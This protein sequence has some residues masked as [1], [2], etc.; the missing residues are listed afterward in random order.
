[1]SRRPWWLGSGLLLIA[2]SALA[3]PPQPKPASTAQPQPPRPAAPAAGASPAPA[4]RLSAAQ[5]RQAVTALLRDPSGTQLGSAVIVA[6][7]RGGHWLVS[8]RHVVQDQR[9]VCVQPTN[10]PAA[11]A[12]VL[13]EPQPRREGG[14]DLALLWLPLSGQPLPVA[15]LASRS[16]EASAL[17]LVVASG[18]PTPLKARLEAVPYREAAGLLLPLLS[19]PLEGG[20]DLAYSAEVEK[21]MSGGGLFAGL[22]L[23]GINGA[24]AQP[25]WPGQWNDASGKPVSAALNAKL[26]L[27]SLGLSVAAI[28]TA[29]RNALPPSPATLAPLRSLRCSASPASVPPRPGASS[30]R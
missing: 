5:H 10:R 28:Q 26:E 2:A 13:P 12:V 3:A 27:V 14:L 7:A 4:S 1:M 30:G 29:L 15:T 8:N 17:P 11:G 23:I 21:G 22:E 18:Y 19:G 6:A 25:L 24:H 20:F 16:P 9:L